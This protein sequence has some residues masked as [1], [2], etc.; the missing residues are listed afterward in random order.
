MPFYASNCREVLLFFSFTTDFLAP[1]KRRGFSP[2]ASAR[3]RSRTRVPQILSFSG[4]LFVS[5]PLFNFLRSVFLRSDLIWLCLILPKSSG[6]RP[7]IQ[8]PRKQ[9][10]KPPTTAEKVEN[11]EKKH[12]E[13]LVRLLWRATAPGLKPLRLPHARDIAVSSKNL[14][15][16]GSKLSAIDVM[17]RQSLSICI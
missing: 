11:S 3:H 9:S 4:W 10:Q 17:Q 5:G 6:R 1:G 13:T 15:P 8:I 7:I 2:G 16:R 12:M 14:V